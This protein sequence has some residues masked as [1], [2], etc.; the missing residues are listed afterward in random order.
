MLINERAKE[1]FTEM[2]TKS[3]ADTDRL[4]ARLMI[5]Q[6]LA[7]VV[8]AYFVSPETWNG[9]ESSIHVHVWAAIFIGGAISA[10][11]GA[12][13]H[14]Y[15]SEKITR[16]LI[17]VAQMCMS[18]L[19]IHVS[20][21]RIESHFHIFGSLAFL[22]FYYDPQVL[23]TAS[24]IT[25]ADHYLR[26]VYWPMSAYGELTVGTWRWLEHGAWVIFEDVFLIYSCFRSQKGLAE[27]SNRQASLEQV[28]SEIEAQIVARTAELEAQRERT[29]EGE[30]MAALGEMAAGMAHEINNPVSVIQLTSEQLQ[31]VLSDENPDIEMSREMA[32]NI[33]MTVGRIG[34]IVR[35]LKSFARDG[36]TDPMV[37]TP[38]NQIIEETLVLCNEKFRNR[39]VQLRYE[40]FPDQL[41]LSCRSVQISQI[42]L[43]LLQNALDAVEVLPEKW[44]EITFTEDSEGTRIMVTDSGGGI[45]EHI[46]EKILQPFFTT[47]EVGKGT[48]LGLS[49]SKGIMDAHHGELSID[50][51]CSNTRFVLNFKRDSYGTKVA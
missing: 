31:D 7:C 41:K 4:F 38:V 34:K 16:H 43:N 2:L 6:W 3:A 11:T 29:L 8:I 13:A 25:A 39:G 26:G 36:E 37:E 30:K 14:L 20:G 12:L 5:F 1:L 51:K 23:I 9:E 40:K 10:F 46:R 42:I 47:K 33:Q 19:I 50:T 18:I 17:A 21:G 22:A 27:I 15:P 32:K 49:I 35:S 44:V 24:L 45:P 28:N 48:G